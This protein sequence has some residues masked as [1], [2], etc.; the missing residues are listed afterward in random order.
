[1]SIHFNAAEIF[2]MAEEIERN[3]AKFY[4]KAAGQ[5]SNEEAKN[6]LS[7]LAAMED[8]HE[9][10]FSSMRAQLSQNEK[11]PV[12][13]DPENQ[14]VL[15]LQAMADGQVFDVHADPSALLKGQ[16]TLGHVLRTAIG[17]EKNSILFYLGLKPLVPA[18][19]GGDWVDKIIQEEMKHVVLLSGYL[20]TAS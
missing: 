11:S 19:L 4:R 8:Q 14:A 5:A 15:Y 17:L 16:E 7:S 20:K 6:R 1:M 9:Q 10:T 3:G 2:E 12:A 18:R 13:F